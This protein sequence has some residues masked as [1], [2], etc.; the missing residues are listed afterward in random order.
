MKKLA[1]FVLVISV[2]SGAVFGQGQEFTFR[3]LP[4]G[5][6]VEDIIAKEGEPDW[7]RDGGLLVYRNVEISGYKAKLTFYCWPQ[8]IGF[9]RGTYDIFIFSSTDNVSDIYNDL[10]RKLSMVYGTP[11]R[12]TNT[13]NAHE[14]YWV[15]SRTKITLRLFIVFGPVIDIIYESPEISGYGNL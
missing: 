2:I 13:Y 3:G 10:L 8:S 4:W 11:T 1:V 9:Y 7:N 14:Y 6:S 5:S 12:E 15:V